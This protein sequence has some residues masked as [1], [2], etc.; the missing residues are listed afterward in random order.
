MGKIAKKQSEVRTE[1]VFVNSAN[2]QKYIPTD[3]FFRRFCPLEIYKVMLYA[4]YALH[5]LNFFSQISIKVTIN[6][7]T[8]YSMVSIHLTLSI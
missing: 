3:Y 7:L 6:P 4:L 2:C 1:Y 8:H 5:M